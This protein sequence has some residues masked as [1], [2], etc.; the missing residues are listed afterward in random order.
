MPNHTHI[1]SQVF[2]YFCNY[3]TLLPNPQTERRVAAQT[4]P[5]VPT[6]YSNK[7][8]S[9]VQNKSNGQWTSY[10]G[11]SYIAVRNVTFFKSNVTCCKA[12]MQFHMQFIRTQSISFI[13]MPYFPEVLLGNVLAEVVIAGC[14]NKHI[15]THTLQVLFKL[16]LQVRTVIKIK[17]LGIDAAV[18]VFYRPN[19]Q[20]TEGWR[21]FLTG[22]RKLPPCY[23]YDPGSLATSLS[24]YKGPE[25][26]GVVSRGRG[27]C[28]E[29]TC[30]SSVSRGWTTN[31]QTLPTFSPPVPW[32]RLADA[33]SSL[34]GKPPLVHINT[35][36]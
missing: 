1:A 20:P 4:T 28:M 21:M 31:Y 25:T 16:Q 9:K 26:W 30:W 36:V 3:Y 6:A 32:G 19:T 35:T 12:S 29:V 7:S 27:G 15:H 5:E 18:L 2:I 23:H 17:L 8:E 22:D 33:W 11:L 10:I 34:V 13:K 14:P 24:A